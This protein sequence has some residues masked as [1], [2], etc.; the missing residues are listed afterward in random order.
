MTAPTVARRPVPA[1]LD[2]WRAL[3]PAQRPIVRPR[4][5]QWSPSVVAWLDQAEADRRDH[6]ERVR[7]AAKVAALA[8]VQVLLVVVALVCR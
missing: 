8:A 7:A 2:H 4:P 5:D 6:Q 3:P 1:T